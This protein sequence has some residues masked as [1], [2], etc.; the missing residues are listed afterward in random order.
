[1]FTKQ[2]RGAFLAGGVIVGEARV[3]AVDS[4]LRY[5]INRGFAL[6]GA[7]NYYSLNAATDGFMSA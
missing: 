6:N 4:T 5:R 3:G 7:N 1:M 2:A